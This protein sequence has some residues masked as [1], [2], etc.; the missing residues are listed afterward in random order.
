MLTKPYCV[1]LDLEMNQ[2][3]GR[4]I[5]VGA[6]VGDLRNAQVLSRFSAFVNPEEP[7][8]PTISDLCGITPETLEIAGSL[9]E[10]YE[11]LTQWLEPFS[12]ERQLNPLT[13]G[14]GD[15]ASLRDQLSLHDVPWIFGRRWLD[16]KTVYIAWQHSR[17]VIPVGGLAPSMK[18]VGLGF[19]GRKHDAADDALNTFVMY[20]RLLELMNIGTSP[21]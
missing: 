17:G 7:L 13:W 11:L 4:I 16:V 19:K 2:P 6:V 3:S 1:S 15:S 9:S 10:A 18:K 14:G 5:Q 20:H 8:A 12:Q 21:A